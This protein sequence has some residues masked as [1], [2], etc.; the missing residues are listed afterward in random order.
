MTYTENTKFYTSSTTIYNVI[1]PEDII[2]MK[3]ERIRKQWWI[4]FV[5][6]IIVC[7]V[8]TYLVLT[9]NSEIAATV[10]DVI[11]SLIGM[12]RHS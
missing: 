10:S 3:T 4:I 2:R 8:V 7:F 5:I 6:F 11:T 1:P 12:F 9:F